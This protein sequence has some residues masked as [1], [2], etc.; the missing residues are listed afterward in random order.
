MSMPVPFLSTLVQALAISGSKT[1]AHWLT[2]ASATLATVLC[3]QMDRTVARTAAVVPNL[4]EV[5]VWV[6]TVDVLD[7]VP[8]AGCDKGCM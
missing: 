5:G 7:T 6:E 1:S 8:A 4:T 3:W 2:S